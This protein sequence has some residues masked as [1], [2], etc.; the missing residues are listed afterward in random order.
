MDKIRVNVVV[1][2]VG[3][4][5]VPVEVHATVA[6]LKDIVARWATVASLVSLVVQAVDASLPACCGLAEH[7]NTLMLI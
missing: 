1:N 3:S 2:G 6:Q 7:V 4:F 5:V